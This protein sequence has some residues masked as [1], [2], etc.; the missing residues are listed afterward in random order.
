MPPTDTIDQLEVAQPTNQAQKARDVST[1]A[2]P[3]A[4]ERVLHN[5]T[6]LPYRSWCSIC[7]QAKAR[8][9]PYLQQK[10]RSPIIH[11]DFAFWGD[12]RGD[13][14]VILTAVDV[15]TGLACASIV[16]SKECSN[17]SITEIKKFIYECGRTYGSVQCDQEPAIAAILKAAIREIGGLSFRHSPKGSSQSQGSVER[18]HQTLFA[19]ARANAFRRRSTIKSRSVH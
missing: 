10:L 6:H 14:A 13:Q 12:D 15:Q 17:Y 8:Q 2:E 3:W 11:G 7:V 9:G 4:T 1:P 18:F 19:Q 16:P 5:L